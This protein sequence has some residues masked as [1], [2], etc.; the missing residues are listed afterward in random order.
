VRVLLLHETDHNV[1]AMAEALMRDGAVVRS[2]SADALTIAE[3]IEAWPPDVVMIAADDPSRDMIEQ[4]CVTTAH[5][6]HPI[7]MFTEADDADAMR[8]LVQAGVA[9][10]VVSGCVPSRLK[11]VI[12]VALER[13]A[14]ER[15][16]H[17]IV[18]EAQARE[19]DQRDVVRAKAFLQRGGQSEA[20]AYAELRQMAMSERRTIADVARRVLGAPTL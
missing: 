20:Q 6:A 7:V 11:S 1:E 14:Y 17:E 18:R 9:A 16:Q 19:R 10:Y 15:G 4:I 12:N 13:F 5:R 2:V 8:S 3:H